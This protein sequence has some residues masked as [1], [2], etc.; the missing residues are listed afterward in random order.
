MRGCKY[1]FISAFVDQKKKEKKNLK[2]KKPDLGIFRASIHHYYLLYGVRFR[3]SE[4]E[5]VE[6]TAENA[7]ARQAVSREGRSWLHGGSGGGGEI[8]GLAG[9]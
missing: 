7:G 9:R 3:N 4:N 1:L 8:S 2:C 6:V 5:S